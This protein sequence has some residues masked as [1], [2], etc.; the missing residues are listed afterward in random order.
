M[1]N[2]DES[3]KWVFLAVVVLTIL[4]LLVSIILAMFGTGSS[5][6]TSLFET[7]TTTWKMGFGAIVG[8]I[9]GKAFRQLPLN[10]KQRR[11]L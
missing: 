4:S 7:C 8:L 6:Q 10:P 9:G 2:Q 11:G 3:F 5:L 1:K